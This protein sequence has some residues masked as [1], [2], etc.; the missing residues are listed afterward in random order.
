MTIMPGAVTF[1]RKSFESSPFVKRVIVPNCRLVGPDHEVLPT[2]QGQLFI[3][4]QSP[5]GPDVADDEFIRL[6]Q[7]ANDRRV[8]AIGQQRATS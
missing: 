3:R 4:D 8:A 2:T 5:D 7:E 6:Y 1:V